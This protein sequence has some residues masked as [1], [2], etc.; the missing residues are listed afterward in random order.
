M[1]SHLKLILLACLL[2]GLSVSL[3]AQN[4]EG[5]DSLSLRYS[6]E[7]PPLSILIDSAV[8]N[9]P[10]LKVRYQAIEA[11]QA[12]LKSQEISWVKNFG[13]QSDIRYGTFDIFSTTTAEGQNPSM[14]ATQNNQMNYGVGAFLKIPIY[15]IV[16]R[17][18][19]I[20]LAKS[21]LEQAQTMA[22]AQ[23]SELRQL[24]IRQYNE[25]LLK[26]KLLMIQS[27]KFSN[28]RINM[29]MVEAQ[30][31]NG[32]IPVDEY[33]RI[34]DMASGSEANYESSKSEFTV[35]FMILEEIVGYN[36]NTTD[37]IRK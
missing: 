32:K 24:V 17:K 36:I 22:D 25:V 28:A 33:V 27:K 26:Q 37:I 9:Y 5:S 34:L 23:L 11:K 6:F 29:D 31:R 21:E 3:R 12:N 7:L 13:I 14:L 30:F 19:Q 20:L 35:S 16:N 1:K 8:K 18:H 10:L 15:E 4:T 2:S